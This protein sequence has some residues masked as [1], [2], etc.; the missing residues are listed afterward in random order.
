MLKVGYVLM[1]VAGAV[2]V[3][4]VL[5]QAVSWLILTAEI[6]LF[7]KVLSLVGGLGIVLTLVGLIIEKR[8]DGENVPCDDE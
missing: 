5:F 4:F 1:L 3:G 6:S 8:K 7:F 2:L